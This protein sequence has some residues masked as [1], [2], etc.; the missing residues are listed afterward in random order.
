MNTF[1]FYMLTIACLFTNN[2]VIGQ[3]IAIQT[4]QKD[5]FY[6]VKV[7]KKRVV[8]AID[9]IPFSLYLSNIDGTATAILPA[10]KSGI[11]H[12]S[13]DE[14]H[15]AC[16]VFI[17]ELTVDLSAEIIY[18][19]V[20]ESLVRKS[21]RL[22]QPSMPGLK[23]I[24]QEKTSPVNVPKQFVTF[25]ENNFPGGL[26]HE[27]FPAMGFIT[28]GNYVVGVLTDAGYKNQYTRNTRRRFTEK[29]G[30]FVGMRNLADAGLFSISDSIENMMENRV[31]AE[32]NLN[33]A[34]PFSKEFIP[35]K[36][37]TDS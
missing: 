19:L 32:V 20:N 6:S 28:P 37:T 36:W 15:L 31:W 1:H 26:V 12:S 18:K 14:I 24:L 29:G 21:V 8:Q 17:P 34:W 35:T 23:Y 11:T 9:E 2:L 30:G 3:S 27:I 13:K 7:L 25:E 33:P 4:V 16:K 22:F 5:S 10:P